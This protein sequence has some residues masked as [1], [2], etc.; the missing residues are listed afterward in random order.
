MNRFT[1]FL[2]LAKLA[3]G[4]ASLPDKATAQIDNRRVEYA[5]TQNGDKTVVFENGLGGA[6][7][8]WARVFPEVGKNTTAFAYDR[9]GY[10]KAILYQRRVTVRT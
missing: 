7:D 2:L 6:M 8:W 5:L 3:S 9:P 1:I 10:G 4:C